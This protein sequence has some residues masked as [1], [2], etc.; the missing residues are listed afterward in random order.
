MMTYSLLAG[1]YVE[2]PDAEREIP[3]RPAEAK[4]PK[5]AEKKTIRTPP[6]Q[7]A[8]QTERTKRTEAE[9]ALGQEKQ[10]GVRLQTRL[11]AADQAIA[12]RDALLETQRQSAAQM[13]TDARAELERVITADRATPVD[14][15][16][17]LQKIL[18]ATRLR[19]GRPERQGTAPPPA[20]TI[21]PPSYEMEVVDRDMNNRPRR[22][23]LTPRKK[24]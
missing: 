6:E 15:I 16:P 12:Q 11:E 10:N 19:T 2:V 8:L 4:R 9:T 5:P 3:L 23:L 22:I 18:Q 1:S 13:L 7:L 21:E 14:P 24:P 20:P 17:W